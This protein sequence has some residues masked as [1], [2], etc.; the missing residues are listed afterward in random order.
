MAVA[1]LC[2][3][4]SVSQEET[5]LCPCKLII[6]WCLLLTL[7]SPGAF[8]PLGIRR[9]RGPGGTTPG[10]TSYG[11]V[12]AA[13]GTGLSSTSPYLSIVGGTFEYTPM[14]LPVR[15]HVDSIKK[16]MVRDVYI[17][18]GS[19][20]RQL[21]KSVFC[22]RPKVAVVGR[23]KGKELFGR[24]LQADADLQAR[25]WTLSGVRLVCDCTPNQQCHGDVLLE[26][27]RRTFP[28]AYDRNAGTEVSDP[29]TL[30]YPQS[31][32]GSTPDEGALPSGAGW[33]GTCPRFTLE[34]GTQ[35]EKCATVRLWRH[36]GDG[37][38]K[39]GGARSM[40]NG[41]LSLSSLSLTSGSTGTLPETN[42]YKHSKKNSRKP[43]V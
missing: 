18:R 26:D 7:S 40:R 16:L 27:F 31:D 29:R 43:F 39:T 4:T 35:Q 22:N 14:V 38:L 8:R 5:G 41:W 28:A 6:V 17:G 24:D 11:M 20:E 1:L 36:Q 34:Q 13:Q 21:R 15:G 23:E 42:P 3:W 12:V 25:L 37:R 30:A 2:P 9:R 32:Q 19:R 10:S 33:R